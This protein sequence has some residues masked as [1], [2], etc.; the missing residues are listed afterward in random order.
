MDDRIT[1]K[2]QLVNLG[3]DKINK[4]VEVDITEGLPNNSMKE[5]LIQVASNYLRSSIIDVRLTKKKSYDVLVGDIGRKVG[6][7]TML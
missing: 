1:I 5:L 7:I 4:T 3:R 6:E 2:L